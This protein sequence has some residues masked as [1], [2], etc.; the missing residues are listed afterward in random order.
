MGCVSVGNGEKRVS[1][2]QEQI[3]GDLIQDATDNA[4]DNS[5]E[6]LS[7]DTTSVT[8]KVVKLRVKF[9][10]ESY[11]MRE[12]KPTRSMQLSEGTYI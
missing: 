4:T 8:A 10:R 12:R 6:N 1:T 7:E 3:R 9:V 5:T 2:E 11:M